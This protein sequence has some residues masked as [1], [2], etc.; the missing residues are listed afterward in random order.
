MKRVRE[1]VD[2]D[3][4]A[5]QQVLLASIVDDGDETNDKELQD[6][7][8]QSM[9][10]EEGRRKARLELIYQ[11]MRKDVDRVKLQRAVSQNE[12]HN[13][14][15]DTALSTDFILHRVMNTICLVTMSR[16]SRISKHVREIMEG[17]VIRYPVKSLH[18]PLQLDFPANTLHPIFWKGNLF[19]RIA[20]TIDTLRLKVRL[21]VAITFFRPLKY[22]ISHR[23]KHIILN[24]SNEAELEWFMRVFELTNISLVIYHEEPEFA[25]YKPRITYAPD[26]PS[27]GLPNT[28]KDIKGRLFN[29]LPNFVK[30]VEY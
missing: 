15:H 11:E 2:D 29:A 23:I 6:A 12:I 17:L 21:D 19:E 30:P 1:E 24:V 20:E 14:Q 26:Q 8:T 25:P 27:K 16:L 13:K 4:D 22:T 10:F 28:I 9:I 7:I 5:L 18:V 3:D